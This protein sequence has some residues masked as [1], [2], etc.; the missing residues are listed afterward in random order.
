MVGRV[1]GTYYCRRAVEG[2]RSF[3]LYMHAYEL[4]RYFGLLVV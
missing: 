4:L 3:D 1:E 2:R